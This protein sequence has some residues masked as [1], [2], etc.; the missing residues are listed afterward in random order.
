MDKLE[1]AFPLS[2]AIHVLFNNYLV[3]KLD[4]FTKRQ[5]QSTN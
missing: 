5:L 3:I 4:K 1:D 2:V